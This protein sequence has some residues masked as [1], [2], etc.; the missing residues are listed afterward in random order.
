MSRLFVVALSLALSAGALAQVRELPRAKPEAVGMSSERLKRVTDT[1]AAD[2]E[3]KKIP[4][5]VILVARHGKVVLYDALGKLDP[6]SGA[7]MP[8]D[9]IFRIYSMTKPITTLTAMM[10]VEEGR[11]QLSDP[12]AKYIPSYAKMQVGVEKPDP[13]GGKATL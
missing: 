7:P 9:A 10:L 11:L 6:A 3:A 8:R 5:A 12:V 1:L 4:G 13:N 2:I